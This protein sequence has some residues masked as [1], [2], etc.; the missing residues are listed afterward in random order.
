MRSLLPVSL[1]LMVQCS[2]DAVC[3]KSSCEASPLTSGT[4]A[5][6]SRPALCVSS[7]AE[8]KVVWQTT[9]VSKAE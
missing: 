5:A 1:P 8:R 6:I 7:V 2:A 3:L 4:K 9:R